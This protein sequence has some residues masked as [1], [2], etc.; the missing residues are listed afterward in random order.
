MERAILPFD[1][2]REDF[3]QDPS[4]NTYWRDVEGLYQTHMG[5]GTSTPETLLENIS[6]QNKLVNQLRRAKKHMIIY[7]TSGTWLCASRAPPDVIVEQ[8]MYALELDTDDVVLFL[9]GMLNVDILQ[10]AFREARKTDRHFA[11]HFWKSVPLPR[12]D[13]KNE[14]HAK[15]AGLATRAE[16]VAASCQRQERKAV[17]ERLREDGVA[18]DIDGMVKEILPNQV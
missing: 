12:Y 1:V 18:G 7:N 14:L 15:L 6:H 2:E 5:K 10:L 8:T 11:A 4:K 3:E 9:A 17:R 13:S 16:R